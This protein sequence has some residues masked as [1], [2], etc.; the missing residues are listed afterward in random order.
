MKDFWSKF[1]P[2]R[3][4]ALAGLLFVVFL[5]STWFIFSHKGQHTEELHVLL[6]EQLKQ[7]IQ[8]T[9]YKKSGGARTMEFQKISTENTDIESEIRAYFQYALS[10]HEGVST[11]VKGQ[12]IL[13]KTKNIEGKHG[14]WNVQHIKTDKASLEFEEPV[15]LLAGQ[16]D[17]DSLSA[18][19]AEGEGETAS[20]SE[21]AKPALGKVQPVSVEDVGVGE[22]VQVSG[23]GAPAKPASDTAK[24]ESAP[25]KP[26]SDTARPLA[27][28]DKA[29][30]ASAESAHVEGVPGEPTKKPASEAQPSAQEAKKPASETQ[31]SAQ[32]K[33]SSE[34]TQP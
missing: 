34:Q 13:K 18:N 17:K 22:Q 21:V 31:P 20:E 15:V 1:K 10:S 25:A 32:A 4:R 3:F 5:V 2:Y 27:S 12:A 14:I 29:K 24:V 19:T 8:D 30:P 11:V 33:P 16:V 7:A 6:Q 26:A 23:A 28:P 9:I